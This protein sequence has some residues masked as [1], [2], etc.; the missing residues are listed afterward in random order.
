MLKNADTAVPAAVP[1]KQVYDAKKGRLKMEMPLHIMLIPGIILTL[2]FAYLPMIGIVMA[3]QKYNPGLGFF[4]SKW[5][6]LDN[7]KFIFKMNDFYTVLYNSFFI[8]ILKITSVIIVSLVLSLLINELTSVKLKKFIQTS[9][10]I[11]YFLSWTLL[12]GIVLEL[13]SLDGIINFF[14]Q[15][16]GFEPIFFMVS[17]RWFPAI[18]VVTDM[19]K[20]M[21]YQIVIF[22]A[23]ITNIN[24]NLYEAAVVDGASKWKQMVYVTLPGMMPIIVLVCTLSIG[25]ILDAGF[26]QVLVLYN[27]LVYKSGDIIDTFVYRMGLLSGQF[28]PAAAVG[29]FRS[30]VSLFLVSSSYAL[31]YKISKYRVF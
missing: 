4:R 5:V 28:S 9:I 21:G 12:G 17:N 10:F 7:F 18:L 1:A 24:P 2:I 29:L 13:F 14:I 23:A 30:F 6:G 20:N 26:E 25:N 19:W 8:S 3:F 31:S 27:P 15:K 22:L 11:P 16:F